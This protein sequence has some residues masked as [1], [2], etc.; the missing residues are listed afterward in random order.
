MPD[1]FFRKEC[2][3]SNIVLPADG[4]YGAG[5]VFL[6]PNLE[7]RNIIE[8]WTEHIIHEEGQKFLGWRQVPHQPSQ[9]GHV[10]RSVMPAFKQ[11]FV[12]RGSQT[13]AEDFDRKLYVIR[14]RLYNKVQEST[15][16]QR[17]FYYFCSL[18]SRTLVYK[19]QLMAEQVDRFFSD[20]AD[21]S[22]TSALAMIHSVI[23]PILSRRGLW[24]TPIA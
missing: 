9:V 1:E 23:V 2:A 13:N 8:Q 24:L 10:A 17:N 21:P 22:M 3:K 4:D 6:P 12:G 14:K 15:L 19:G 11:L 18:A 5:N 16:G 20:L 7:D